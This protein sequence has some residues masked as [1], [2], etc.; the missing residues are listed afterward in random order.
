MTF[1]LIQ[2]SDT[3]LSPCKAHFTD[4][5]T[6]LARWVVNEH[7]DLVIHTGDVT[8]DGADVEE[9]MRC[10]AELMRGVGVRFRAVPGNHDVGDAGHI[11]QSVNEERLQRWRT[12]FGPDRWVED[13]ED[14]RLIG[15]DA[16]GSV[17]KRCR[18]AG[19]RR[20]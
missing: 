12:H 7:P 9:D 17:K 2:I 1:R 19:S 10:S 8:V 6:P 20:S 5:W 4:N 11:H 14:W 15:L 13:I 16:L 3:H 18:W